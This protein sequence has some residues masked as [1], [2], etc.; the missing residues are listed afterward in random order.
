MSQL[1]E[2]HC[3]SHNPR[4]LSFSA[5]VRKKPSRNPANLRSEA[6]GILREL[7][8][9]YHAVRCVRESMMADALPA[10]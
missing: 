2:A 4:R 10:E 3:V 8:L 9:V 6:E 5:P 7:A 1:V